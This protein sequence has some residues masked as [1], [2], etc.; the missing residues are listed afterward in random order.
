MDIRVH[1]LTRAQPD[2]IGHQHKLSQGGHQSS[3]GAFGTSKRRG[4]GALENGPMHV[5]VQWKPAGVFRALRHEQGAADFD[6]VAEVWH[7]IK[8]PVHIDVVF[9]FKNIG[10]DAKQSRRRGKLTLGECGLEFSGLAQCREVK[11]N[12]AETQRGRN[13]GACRQ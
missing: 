8:D 6:G 2:V 3:K 13:G 12:R 9:R 7:V 5:N 1:E 10:R 4:V 11:P